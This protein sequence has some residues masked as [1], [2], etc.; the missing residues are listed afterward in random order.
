M[1]DSNRALVRSDNWPQLFHEFVMSRSA[2]P[3]R[4]GHNDCALF[5]ADAINAMCGVDLGSGLRGEYDSLAGAVVQMQV[6]TDTPRATVEN[7]AEYFA[8]SCQMPERPG[9]LFA[10]RGD[11]VL[12]DSELG[13]AMGVVDLDGIRCLFVAQAGLHEMPLKACRR[14]WKV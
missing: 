5:V 9:P 6:L 7:V 11:I 2:L 3:F 13:P 8:A 4:W 14:A 1:Q 10:Q 12:L